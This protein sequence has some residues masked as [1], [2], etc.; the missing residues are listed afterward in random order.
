MDDPTPTRPQDQAD[1][2]LLRIVPDV[3]DRLGVSRSTVYG[4]VS[5]GALVLRKVGSS[6]RIRSDELDAYIRSLPQVGVVA[7]EVRE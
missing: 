5:E 3:V 6:S 7:V 4:L 2:R 1:V